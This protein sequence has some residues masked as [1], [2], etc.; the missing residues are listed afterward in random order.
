MKDLADKS[1]A[2]ELAKYRTEFARFR[3]RDAADRTLMAWIRTALSLITFGFGM[4]TI[5]GV[6]QQSSDQG[7][8]F[9]LLAVVVGLSFVVVGVFSLMAALWSHRRSLRQIESGDFAYQSEK[10]NITEIAAIA[11]LL[12]GIASFAGVLVGLTLAR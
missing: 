4:P 8:Y 6:L 5:L 1:L 3:T 12:I 2:D 10:F 11:L 7:R 9:Q